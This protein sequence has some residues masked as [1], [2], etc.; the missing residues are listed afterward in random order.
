[1]QASLAAEPSLLGGA[2]TQIVVNNRV[3]AYINGKPITVIDLMKKMDMQFLRQFPEFTSSSPA[4]YQYYLVNWRH[5]LQELIDKQLVLADAE[6]MKVPLSAGDVRQEMEE[7]FGPNIIENL[8]KIGLS[9]D[10]AFKIVQGDILIRRMMMHRVNSKAFRFLTPQAI[11]TAYEDFSKKNVKQE[12]WHYQVVTIRNLST[13]LGENTS[14]NAYKLLTEEQVS[15]Q[16][17]I[18]TLQEKEMIQ[19]SRITVS[20]PFYH[21]ESELSD[22]V[23]NSLKE[24]APNTYSKPVMQKSRTDKNMLYRIIYL[25]EKVPGGAI[26]FAEIENQLKDQLYEKAV[27]KESEAY[28]KKLHGH[29]FIKDTYISDNVPESF[30]PFELK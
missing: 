28:L 12:T 15:L 30:Q 4:R 6:E 10:E 11:R 1:M 2:P 21:I 24:M 8:D 14:Q 22:F 29:Y 20:E 27:A 25:Q 16:D 17:L 23:K 13:T 5:V 26:P 19:K 3:L 7:L 9:F 18:K